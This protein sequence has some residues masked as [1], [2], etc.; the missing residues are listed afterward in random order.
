[1]RHYIVD[2]DNAERLLKIPPSVVAEIQADALRE[3]RAAIEEEYPVGLAQQQFKAIAITAINEL[4]EDTHIT[5][6]TKEPNDG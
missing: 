2:P 3:A 1:M 4:L 5:N 6:I